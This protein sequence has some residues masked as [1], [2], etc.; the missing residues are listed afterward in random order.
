MWV[1]A[2]SYTSRPYLVVSELIK[3]C[4]NMYEIAGMYYD[5]PAYYLRRWCKLSI[6]IIIIVMLIITTII[7]MIIS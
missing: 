6:I 5:N 3:Y 1:H 7:L 4:A 2:H